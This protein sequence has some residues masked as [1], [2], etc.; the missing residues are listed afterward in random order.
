MITHM[1]TD[2]PSVQPVTWTLA[3]RLRKARQSASLTQ[4]ALAGTLGLSRSTVNRYETGRAHPG[5]AVLIAWAQATAVDMDFL[6]D[7]EEVAS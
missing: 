5:R 3:D 1:L 2:T 4:D 7:A 6:N